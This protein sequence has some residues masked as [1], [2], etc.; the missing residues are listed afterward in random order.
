MT[1]KPIPSTAVVWARFRF[2]VVG[3]LLSAPPPRGELKGAIQSLADKIWTH[4]VTGQDVQYAATTIERWFY[5]ARN[6]QDDPVGVLRR[7]VRKD[8]GNMSA[9]CGISTSITGRSKWSPGM[10]SGSG[11]WCWAS[12]MTTR[13]C[14]A[15]CSGIF[16]R[17]PKT[18]CMDF[19][20]R[21]RNGVSPAPC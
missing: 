19:R 21:F 5:K 16:R 20:R 2:S 4:P 3:P 12:W 9:P 1:K 17:P 6:S 7:A 13:D 15:I 11:Q 10:A 18:W 8:A 14:A